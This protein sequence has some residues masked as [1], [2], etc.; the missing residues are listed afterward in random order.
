MPSTT[1]AGLNNDIIKVSDFEGFVGVDVTREETALQNAVSVITNVTDE[2]ATELGIAILKAA[3]AEA[4]DLGAG[5]A[6]V[7]VIPDDVTDD[8]VLEL[9]L[10]RLANAADAAAAAPELQR[11]LAI[12]GIGFALDDSPETVAAMRAL[13]GI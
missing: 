12:M 6:T 8:E 13:V 11:A 5:P 3:G 4:T 7:T 2:T 9:L 10:E 1:F